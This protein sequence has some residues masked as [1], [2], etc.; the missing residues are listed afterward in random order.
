MAL[1]MMALSIMA[2]GITI[3][4]AIFGIMAFSITI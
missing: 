1:S 2:F 4:N 3:K